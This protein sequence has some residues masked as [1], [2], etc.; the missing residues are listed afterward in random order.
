MYYVDDY[1]IVHKGLVLEKNED[2]IYVNGLY[3][4]KDNNGLS[5]YKTKRIP[6]N[7]NL[8]YAVFD[9]VGG[10]DKGELASYT[11]AILLNK[12][13][14]CKDV[15]EIINII[16]NKILEINEEKN[17]TCGTTLTILK[18][19]KN[20]LIV[21]QVGDSPIYLYANNKLIKINE[22]H[23]GNLLDNYIGK[24]KNIIVNIKEYKLT[25][26][27]KILICSDGIRD[28]ISDTDVEYLLSSTANSL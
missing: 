15:E 10:L 2:N 6:L 1:A 13:F 14:H 22:E 9:G 19:T 24:S 5:N 18:I 25:K 20:R 7:R 11:S 26:H 16:N 27:D 21:Y 4:D 8:Y 12:Y 28:S 3:L 17:I 23:D